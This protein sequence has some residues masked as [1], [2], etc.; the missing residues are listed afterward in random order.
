MIFGPYNKSSLLIIKE[1]ELHHFGETE[2]YD[3]ILKQLDD[4]GFFE[5]TLT[6]RDIFCNIFFGLLMI[7]TW[8]VSIT[9]NP[10]SMYYFKKR[11]SSLVNTLFLLLA[12]SDFLTNLYHPLFISVNLFSP[13]IVPFV[14]LADTN[15]K[16]RSYVFMVANMSALFLTAHI[17]IA[18]L[19]AI[20]Y[21]FKRA[22]K[23]INIFLYIVFMICVVIWEAFLV[24]GIYQA[25]PFWYRFCQNVYSFYKNGYSQT[26]V[27]AVNCPRVFVATAGLLSSFC[28][29]YLLK[30]R[31]KKS[32]NATSMENISKSSVAILIMNVGNIL[33]VSFHVSYSIVKLKYPLIN[34]MA[35]SLGT[36]VLSALNPAI[37][38]LMSSEMK[39][40][41]KGLITAM[42]KCNGP[43]IKTQQRSPAPQMHDKL[44]LH[45]Q[46]IQR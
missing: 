3:I 45:P 37:K 23:R 30:F 43:R 46:I 24:F 35:T 29:L 4:N 9:L 14:E 16:I 13:D 22:S 12:V 34:F 36:I 28:S 5:N 38:I 40:A 15:Q 41:L 7:V 21:P 8:V 26:M 33:I 31:S 10:F 17:S 20:K 44:D 18:R 11:G 42:N 19:F 25:K 27:R 39:S 1:Y 32:K 6:N 2:L